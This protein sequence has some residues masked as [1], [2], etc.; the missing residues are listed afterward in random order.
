MDFAKKIVTVILMKLTQKTAQR[1]ATKQSEL[2]SIRWTDG[3]ANTD[4]GF[5]ELARMCC[6]QAWTELQSVYPEYADCRLTTEAPDIQCEFTQGS[7]RLKTNI[8]LK[9]AKSLTMPGSTIG[10]LNINEPV[11][12]CFRPTDSTQLF[13]FKYSQY[14]NAMGESDIDKFQDRTP[15]PFLNF[16]KM[17]DVQI[18]LEYVEKAKD[19]WVQHYARCAVKRVEKGMNS[20]WQDTMIQSVLDIYLRS[21]S[22]EDIL[23]RRSALLQVP[24]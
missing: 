8:E 17:T 2:R 7:N 16:M 11:I 4:S 14:H 23:A 15:R 21:H 13:Q 1:L 6:M 12:F 18:P 10:K 22:E 5:S 3:E 20:S 24:L 19:D 9:S